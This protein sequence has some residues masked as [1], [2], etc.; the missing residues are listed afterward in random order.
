VSGKWAGRIAAWPLVTV[1]LVALNFISWLVAARVYHLSP[2]RAQNSALLLKVGATNGELLR[3]GEWWRILTSQFLHVHFPHMVFNMAALFLLGRV[4]ERES[5]HWRLALLFA[6]SGVTGQLIGVAAAPSLVSSGASQAVM[7]LAAWVIIE[8]LRRP[9]PRS[10]MPVITLAVVCVQVL[11]DVFTAG[12]I[13]AGHLG[14][15]LAG[16]ILKVLMSRDAQRSV[17]SER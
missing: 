5:G 13:K 3:A 15:F 17:N 9:Q 10:F 4:V 2:L 14:G 16:A 6:L 8:Y 7:G 12:G 1:A 11:L